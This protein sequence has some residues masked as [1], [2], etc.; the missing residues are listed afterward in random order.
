MTNE[1][2]RAVSLMETCI[3]N[4]PINPTHYRSSPSGL[5]CI[6]VVEH[7]TFNIGNAVKKG[8]AI[9]DLEKARWY[10]NREITKLSREREERMLAEAR[11]S[12]EVKKVK[13]SGMYGKFGKTKEKRR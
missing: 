2:G 7:M 12:G 8:D 13:A 1:V 3:K 4:D 10:L 6:D 5:Q 9:Q 11:A